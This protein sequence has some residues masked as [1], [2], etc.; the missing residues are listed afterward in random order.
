MAQYYVKPAGNDGLAGTSIALA[1]AS[2]N[3]AVITMA[4]GDTTDVL[5]GT[6]AEDN[7]AFASSGGGIGTPITLQNYQSDTVKI[8][9]AGTNAVILYGGGNKS[10]L[11]ID[12]IDFEWQHNR[13][14]NG[15]MIKMESSGNDNIVIKNCKFYDETHGVT[16]QA[17]YAGGY[18]TR[19]IYFFGDGMEVDN[20]EFWNIQHPLVID[21]GHTQFWVHDSHWHDCYQSPAMAGSYAE[22]GDVI[23]D[24]IIEESYIEDGIQFS[25]IDAGTYNNLGIIVRNNIIRGNAENALDLKGCTNICIEGNIIYGTIGSNDGPV[26][27]WGRTSWNTVMAGTGT[28]TKDIIIRN[29]IIYDNC[30]VIRAYGG[31]KIYNNTFIS[32]NRD[33]NGPDQNNDGHY[34]GGP[35]A[36]RQYGGDDHAFLNNICL[37]HNEVEV[38][39]ALGNPAIDI[40]YN[41]YLDGAHWGDFNGPAWTTYTTLA[42]WR[43]AIAATA[44]ELSS[45]QNSFQVANIAA[46][47]F[48][49]VPADPD[50]VTGDYTQFDFRLAAGSPAIDAGRHLTNAVGGDTA[51][52]ITVDDARFFRD[53]YG[54]AAGVAADWF[55]ING[56]R[57]LIT[58]VNYATNVITFAGAVVVWLDGDPVYFDFLDAAPCI[59]AIEYVVIGAPGP[60]Q[61]TATLLGVGSMSVAGAGQ[62]G[63]GE[64]T[65]FD[66]IDF[67]LTMV[68]I[69]GR[70]LTLT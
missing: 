60:D 58:A 9:G 13:T 7:L 28:V 38:M 45:E 53:D 33:F 8:V 63:G 12:G 31:F 67:R 43:S 2:I 37:N 11:I 3:K 55:Y 54:N 65:A 56:D 21:T 51:N 47:K 29:N 23:E 19:G 57:R 24:C 36:W 62:G 16:P 30:P 59:G 25:N 17:V 14:G 61:G 27:G 15:Y 46:V 70:N 32:N 35:W 66:L 34:N 20:C 48:V 39:L 26:G 69:T 64:P 52:A 49:D 22:L 10:W 42:N 4:A 6:Y 5:A 44:N 1:W 50:D 18:R 68:E 41:I 40:D